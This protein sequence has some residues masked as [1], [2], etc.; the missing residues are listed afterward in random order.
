MI[1]ET[2]Y[3]LHFSNSSYDEEDANKHFWSSDD[4]DDHDLIAYVTHPGA[5]G[6]GP[7]EVCRKNYIRWSHTKGYGPSQ[8]NKYDPPEQM[9]CTPTNRL[10]LTAE[11][12]FISIH[13]VLLLLN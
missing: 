3:F 9:E 5:S 8:C 1:S 2:T 12:M 10:A 4:K 7:G 11:V 6:F 13:P